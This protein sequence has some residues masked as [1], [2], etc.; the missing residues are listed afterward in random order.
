MNIS[1]AAANFP[2]RDADETELFDQPAQVEILSRET[3]FTGRVWNIEHESFWYNEGKISRDYVDHTGAVAVLALD[4]NDRLITIRQYRHPI[5]MREWEIPAGLLDIAGESPLVAAQRELAEEVDL[6]ADFWSVLSDYYTSP[7]GSN[8][9]VRIFLARDV[10][11]IPV[12]YERSDEEADMEVR[13]VSLDDAHR[14]VLAGHV[15]N[16]IFS[17]AILTAYA[18]RSQGWSSLRDA[19]APWPML[20]WR[21][22]LG[23]G[24]PWQ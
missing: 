3:V 5:R 24:A 11:N 21:N 18:S 4:D 15:S 17:I 14:A 6:Q 1:A 7:G 13:W 8:E 20:N 12:A 23:S 2:G 22:A 10:H 16:S 9:I 19:D